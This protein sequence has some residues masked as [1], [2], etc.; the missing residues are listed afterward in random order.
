MCKIRLIYNK[1]LWSMAIIIIVKTYQT[2]GLK[3]VSPQADVRRRISASVSTS[4]YERHILKIRI[5][6]STEMSH[7]RTTGLSSDD[8]LSQEHE[9]L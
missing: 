5:I 2:V 3:V 1:A 8:V 4:H 6:N 7:A 9:I